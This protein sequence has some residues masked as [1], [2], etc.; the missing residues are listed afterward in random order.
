ML[1]QPL[2]WIKASIPRLNFMT[3][4]ISTRDIDSNRTIITTSYH[5]RSEVMW[6][7][8]SSVV[9]CRAHIPKVPGSNLIG[10]PNSFFFTF[11]F[12]HKIHDFLLFIKKS[13]LMLH[14]RKKNCRPD[15]FVTQSLLSLFSVRNSEKQN[16]RMKKFKANCGAWH[17]LNHYRQL[18]VCMSSHKSKNKGIS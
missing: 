6:E 13:T 1:H 8:F 17:F 3:V 16:K 11:S 10:R 12:F 9:E 18:Q 15:R 14:Q 5:S 7:S 4:L 2:D